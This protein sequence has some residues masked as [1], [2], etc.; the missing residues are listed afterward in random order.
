MW[1]LFTSSW[2][3][4]PVTNVRR[5][6][7]MSTDTRLRK[8]CSQCQSRYIKKSKKNC[9]LYLCTKCHALFKVPATKEC[10]NAADLPSGL[11][12]IIKEKRA[13]QK[14]L[15]GISWSGKMEIF[16]HYK[17]YVIDQHYSV[18]KEYT[19]Q[20]SEIIGFILTLTELL[21]VAAKQLNVQIST[22]R[23]LITF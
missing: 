8:I 18:P 5:R 11:V 22:L 6:C 9:G 4:L 21:T 20:I 3:C 7:G 17:K 10:K 23:M 15:N 16:H 1:L 14:V 12:K 2:A 13:K 19:L